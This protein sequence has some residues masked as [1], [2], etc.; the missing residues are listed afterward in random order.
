MTTLKLNTTPI[1]LPGPKDYWVA[2]MCDDR[3]HGIIVAEFNNFDQA[4]G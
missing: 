2:I 1:R 3:C 4:L